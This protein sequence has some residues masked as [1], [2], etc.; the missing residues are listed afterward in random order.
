MIDGL[1]LINCNSQNAGWVEWV[2]N[3]INLKSLRK[4][5][6]SGGPNAGNIVTNNSESSIGNLPLPESVVD[7]LMWYH[8]GRVDAEGR[9]LDAMSI[10]SIYK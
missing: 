9:G 3:K 6:K 5:S 1:I 7:Y 8:L 2:Y 4:Q 10:A